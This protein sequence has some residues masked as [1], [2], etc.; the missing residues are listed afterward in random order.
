M[1]FDLWI[2]EGESD[3]ND[4]NI[5]LSGLD[6]PLESSCHFVLLLNIK[7][8]LSISILMGSLLR[9][10][11]LSL[12]PYRKKKVKRQSREKGPSWSGKRR[13]G[14]LG[15]AKFQTLVHLSK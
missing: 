10:L 5:C 14:V 15:G 3:W 4:Y 2:V 7:D 9:F 8:E 12:S 1:I 11:S 13:F 6:W